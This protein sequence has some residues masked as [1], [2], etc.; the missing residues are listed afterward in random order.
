MFKALIDFVKN[1][2]A[3]RAYVCF[4]VIHGIVG[5]R[6]SSKPF[7][8]L[9]RGHHPRKTRPARYHDLEKPCFRV[10][11][12]HTPERIPPETSPTHI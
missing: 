9:L 4:H 2:L 11:L 6:I 3:A 5:A 10:T 8:C 7:K 1:L 12:L